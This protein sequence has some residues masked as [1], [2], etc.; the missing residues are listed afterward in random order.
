[1]KKS[2][3]PFILLFALPLG[4]ALLFC[5]ISATVPLPHWDIDYLLFL[6]NIREASGGIIT[7]IMKVF[8][9]LGESFM[10]LLVGALFFWAIDKKSGEYILFCDAAATALNQIVKLTACTYRPWIRDTRI[11]PAAGSKATATG[12]SFPS[13]HVSNSGTWLGGIAVHFNRKPV[14]VVCSIVW[15]LIGLSRNFLGVHTP[16]DVIISLLLTLAVLY[17]AHRLLAFADSGRKNADVIVLICGTALSVAMLIFA[18]VKSYPMDY[19]NGA[20]LVDPQIMIIDGFKTAGLV[21]GFAAG[22]FI[23]RRFIRFDTSAT[24]I[25][26]FVRFIVGAAILAGLYLLISHPF[27][28]LF[29][30]QWGGFAVSV[31]AIFYVMAIYPFC[32]NRIGRHFGKKSEKNNR[33]S[34]EPV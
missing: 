28:T 18:S 29:G 5:L 8:T 24:P 26:L 32:F 11:V 20:I 9:M 17:A 1:M 27:K 13:G 4:I 2:R 14:T 3:K 23:E 16:Q 30:E 25:W 22:W 7:G 21:L 33:S 12:Y 19:A 10:P 31:V 15:L 34:A 6:Q